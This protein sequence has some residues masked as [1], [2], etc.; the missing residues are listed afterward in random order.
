M[1]N[2]SSPKD[3][4]DGGS[5]ATRRLAANG[6]GVRGLARPTAGALGFIDGQPRLMAPAS[7]K[8]SI[9]KARSL[10]PC[11]GRSPAPRARRWSTARDSSTR[12]RRFQ[13]SWS[14]A[15]PSTCR[16]RDR[17]AR[18]PRRG[19]VALERGRRCRAQ[20]V[21]LPQDPEP[22]ALSRALAGRAR[23]PGA[24]PRGR[25][26][27]RALRQRWRNRLDDPPVQLEVEAIYAGTDI[28]ARPSRET[29]SRDTR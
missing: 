27:A 2:T 13:T 5:S 15:A 16:P 14:P 22:E 28:A 18:D 9:I 4:A 3:M 8:H 23:G 11:T 19:D 24:Q 20:V 21:Q 6:R 26:L 25:P 12:S 17:R 1:I 7:M 29:A 10:P